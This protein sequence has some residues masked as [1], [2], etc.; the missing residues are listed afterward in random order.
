MKP[1][2]SGDE[3]MR[4]KK[5]GKSR[6]KPPAFLFYPGDFLRNQHVMMMTYEERG[7]YITLLSS[8]WLEG[9]IPADLDLLSKL[10]RISRDEM[11]RLWP[12][13]SP[14]FVTKSSK[15]KTG[16]IN[17]RLEKERKKQRSYRKKQAENAKRGIEKRKS[18]KE[19]ASVGT[20]NPD[21]KPQPDGSFSY[22]ISS[23]FSNSIN[24]IDIDTEGLEKPQDEIAM[25][26][27][28][29]QSTP[30][31]RDLEIE[32]ILFDL[33]SKFARCGM[34]PSDIDSY[35]RQIKKHG[36]SL[37]RVRDAYTA[38]VDKRDSGTL[39]NAAKYFQRCLVNGS[40]HAKAN[41]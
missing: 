3:T 10:L 23:S 9:S 16:L 41:Y 21:A 19:D 29:E 13:I 38:L 28:L 5:K 25:N 34:K 26:P 14:C 36:Y 37:Q 6:V 18:N 12:A 15:D 30:P 1:M 39:Q 31:T 32:N 24:N 2:L 11:E 17:P 40:Q 8:E 22:S 35:K 4:E 27:E 20:A 33:E 7:I